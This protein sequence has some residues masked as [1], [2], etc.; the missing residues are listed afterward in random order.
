MATLIERKTRY[1]V[2]LRNNDRKSRPLMNRLIHEM[3]PLP[4]D[5]NALTADVLAA[6][7]LPVLPRSATT[8]T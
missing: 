6:I 4:A 8:R 7:G 3:S 1:T 2:L 5:P